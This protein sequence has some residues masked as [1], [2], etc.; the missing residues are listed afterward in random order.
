VVDA[1]HQQPEEREAIRALADRLGVTFTGLWLQA[2]VETLKARVVARTRDASDADAAVVTVQVGRTTGDIAWRRIDAS[3]DP[4]ATLARAR[5]VVS[6]P[7]Q[8]G[9]R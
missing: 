5:A 2:P 8:Q 6:L 1:V 4:D 7:L 3:G 9:G